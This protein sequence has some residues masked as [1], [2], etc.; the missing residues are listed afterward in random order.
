MG[1]KTRLIY[2]NLWRKGGNGIASTPPAE[3]QHPVS[4]TQID[5]K[6]MFWRSSDKA[7][8]TQLIPMDLGEGTININFIAIL[9]HNILTGEGQNITVQEDNNSNFGSIE[10]ETDAFT[11]QEHNI[12]QFLA[13]P[14][15]ERYIQVKIVRTGGG[16]F[17]T[18]P[19]IATILCGK[20]AELNRRFAPE[21]EIGEEDFSEMEYS[22]SQVLFAQE[23]ETLNIRR[24]SYQALNN[25]SV[26]EI[27]AM[28]KE[29]KSIKAFAFCHDYSNPNSNTL[30]VRNAELNSP[31]CRNGVWYWEMAIKEII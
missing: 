18:K 29:C 11:Y 5:T 25:A 15:T 23:R 9:G 26:T 8:E 28:F 1:A 27:L 20:Y 17:T 13:T 21:Y 10:A 4:D 22:D 12:F 31:V 16:E 30:W 14:L 19:Q 3:A 6:S 24:Y 2:N 7:V